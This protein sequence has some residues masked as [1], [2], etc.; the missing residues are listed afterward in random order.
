MLKASCV[1]NVCASVRACA[2][3]RASGA[4]TIHGRRA[5]ALAAAAGP[6]AEARPADGDA[7]TQPQ[8]L[9]SSIP[10][11]LHTGLPRAVSLRRRLHLHIWPV[12]RRGVQED[13]RRALFALLA[14]QA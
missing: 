3:V 14:L 5:R 11:R 4:A 12:V 8:L 7:Y 13:N 2:Y 1:A 6:S 9:P 10:R